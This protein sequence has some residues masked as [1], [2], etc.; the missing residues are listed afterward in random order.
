MPWS[1]PLVQ[2]MIDDRVQN[3]DGRMP[4]RAEGIF[5]GLPTFRGRVAASLATIC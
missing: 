4:R 3:R 5:K 1:L 2:Q